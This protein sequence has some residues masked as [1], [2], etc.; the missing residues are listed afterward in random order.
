MVMPSLVIALA[1][2]VSVGMVAGGLAGWWLHRRRVSALPVAPEY[3]SIDPDVERQI[4]RAASL[5]AK[6]HQQPQAAPLVADRLRLAYLLNQRR[7]RRNRRG[8]RPW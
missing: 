1:A 7:Q 6:A 8:R 3:L 5:W 4:G 2:G